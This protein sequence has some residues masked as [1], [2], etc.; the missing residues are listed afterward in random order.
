MFWLLE[1]KHLQVK[2]MFPLM[3]N[4]FSL[5]EKITFTDK[6]MCF[7]QDRNYVCTTGKN[8]FIVKIMCSH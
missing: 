3:G 8:S 6:N 2:K 1:K 7:H 5:E 4:M